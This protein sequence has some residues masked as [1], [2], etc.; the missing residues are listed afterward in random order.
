MVFAFVVAGMLGVKMLFWMETPENKLRFA[1]LS[2]GKR[3]VGK[4][5]TGIKYG[6]TFQSTAM[7]PIDYKV[8]PSHVSI[9]SGIN[10]KPTRQITG[11]VVQ[12]G[13]TGIF[14]EAEVPLTREITASGGVVE[15][16]FEFEFE[17]EFEYG[18]PGKKRFKETKKYITYFQFQPNGDLQSFESTEVI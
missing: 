4:K 8:T 10:P 2:L 18:R 12:Q 6:I 14:W 3:Y 7:F 16:E 17:F 11:G 1:A 15:G 13:A 9:G 5:L